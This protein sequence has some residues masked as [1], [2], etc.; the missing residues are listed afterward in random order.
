MRGTFTVGNV[1]SV[2]K[3]GTGQGTVT[4]SPAGVNC[5]PDCNAP[6]PGGDTVTLTAVAAAGSTFG[7]WTGEGCTG[8]GTCTVTVT[9]ARLVTATFGAPDGGDPPATGPPAAFTRVVVSKVRGIRYVTVTLHVTRAATA[10][11]AVVRRSKTLVSAARTFAAGHRAT[12]LRVPKRPPKGQA[13]V[14]VTLKD[15]A[16]GQTFVLRKTIRLP[17]P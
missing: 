8:T 6:F 4:S 10:K 2:G 7:G 17:A 1:L 9:G 16:S 14:K 3:A 12:K 15:V 5:G 13:T 11:V